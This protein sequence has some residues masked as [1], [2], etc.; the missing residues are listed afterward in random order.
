M[1]S[2]PEIEL[3]EVCINI[4]VGYVGTMADEYV[5][6]GV[7]FLRSQN[8]LPYRLNLESDQ[9]KYIS[10]D[11]NNKIS[12]SILNSGDIA[13]VRTGYPGTAC[14]IPE[15]FREVNCADLVIV[16][17][18]KLKADSTFL[19]Y[20]INSPVGKGAIFGSLVGVAQQHFNVGV[21]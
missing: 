13:I 2:W 19:C 21:A 5:D 20:Y 6:R 8:I 17:P 3:D 4:T 1:N 16:R 11:F 10:S 9:I 7:L 15:G 12:K 14:V 18:D